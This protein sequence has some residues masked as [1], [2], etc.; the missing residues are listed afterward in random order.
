MPT[1]NV[2]FFPFFTQAGFARLIFLGGGAGA[3]WIREEYDYYG[4]QLSYYNGNGLYTA[5]TSQWAPILRL[6]IGATGSGGQFGFGGELR[7]NIRPLKQNNEAFQT[8]TA[9]NFNSVDLTLRFYFSL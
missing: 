6:M 3:A 7:Y 8:R 9:P 4:G 2:R 1:V 5:S